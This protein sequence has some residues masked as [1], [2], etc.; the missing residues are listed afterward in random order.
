MENEKK[1]KSNNCLRLMYVKEIIFELTDEDHFIT[2]NEISDILKNNY[3]ITATRQTLYNDIELLIE[4][5]YDI[6]CIKGQNNMYHVL[7]R[8]FDLAELRILIDAVGSMRSLSNCQSKALIKKLSRQGG[9]SAEFLRRN[10]SCN[11]IPKTDNNQIYYIIDTIN[12]AILQNKQIAFKYYEYFTTSEKVLKNAGKEYH[13]S[14]YRLVWSNDFYY[15]L[16][17]SD[18][19][20]KISAYRVDRICGIPTILNWHSKPEPKE[21]NTD[22][23]VQESYHM[24]SGTEAKVILEFS[25]SVTDAM[26]DRFGQDLNIT[27]ICRDTCLAQVQVQVNNALFAWI[28]GF[29]GKVRIK[30]PSEVV[31]QYIRMVSKEMARL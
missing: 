29:E 11:E 20:N 27:Y 8:E 1:L 25:S 5:G 31:D 6:E 28:F 24:L 2:I 16:A 12:H 14:P 7:S 10:V 18:K 21:M 15:L 22:K 26:I 23:Y 4:A 13:V 9:P 17:F 3:A 30:K 19:H